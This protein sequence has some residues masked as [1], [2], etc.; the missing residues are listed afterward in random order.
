MRLRRHVGFDRLQRLVAGEADVTERRRILRHLASCRECRSRCHFVRSL[1]DRL[2][3]ATRPPLPASSIDRIRASRAAGERII[4]PVRDRTSPSAPFT[5]ARRFVAAAAIVLATSTLAWLALRGTAEAD[6]PGGELTLE[7]AEPRAGEW[8]E[9]EYRPARDLEGEPSLVLRGVVAPIV[10][11]D[12]SLHPAPRQ[13]TVLR[14]VDGAYRGRFLFGEGDV[15]AG[16]AVENRAGTIVDD[17]GGLRWHLLAHDDAGR[18]LR[19][20]LWMHALLAAYNDWGEGYEVLRRATELYPRDPMIV[21][22][23][24]S[25]ELASSTSPERDSALAVHRAKFATLAESK[26]RPDSLDPHALAGLIV[27]AQ[28]VGDTAAAERLTTLLTETYPTQ[29]VAMWYRVP[30]LPADSTG[31]AA[32]RYLAELEALWQE[33]GPHP[34]MTLAGLWAARRTGRPE[35]ILRWARRGIDHAVD[36]TSRSQIALALAR[37]P[38]VRDSSL[39]YLRAEIRRLDAGEVARPLGRTTDR[40][41]VENGNAL[42]PLLAALSEVLLAQGKRAAALDSL[43]AA[44]S[45]GTAS[46]EIYA[47]LAE[48]ELAGGDTIAAATSLARAVAVR[49][50]GPSERGLDPSLGPTLV[51]PDRWEIMVR[52]ARDE[53]HRRLLAR[54]IDRPLRADPVYVF[55]SEGAKRGF[56][57]LRDGTVTVVALWEPQSPPAV[58][59]LPELGRVTDLV[60]ALGGEVIVVT[61]APPGERLTTLLNEHRFGGPLYHD[62]DRRVTEAFQTVVAPEYFVLDFDGRIRFDDSSLEDVLPQVDALLDEPRLEAVAG[63]DPTGIE[64]GDEE[65]ERR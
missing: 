37:T 11:Y 30:P 21:A 13:L 32:D 1:P 57:E 10:R 58:R 25:L 59:A 24:L 61:R 40:Q 26:T 12:R 27:Y 2:A 7:P 56:D 18:P 29:P 55:D 42:R 64:A 35:S 23:R 51:S 20:A 62:R 36:Q 17:R 33:G 48:I 60:R 9:V 39:P 65:I 49:F 3:S 15:Y 5:G 52:S 19:D 28:T 50:A 38:A 16:L 31:A 41:R 63:R 6:L 14:R 22:S 4:L 43:R 53:M 45:L 8:I 44:A 47:R 54:S 46:R 34:A